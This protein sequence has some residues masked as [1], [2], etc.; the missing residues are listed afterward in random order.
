MTVDAFL[1]IIKTDKTRYIYAA[2]L[3]AFENWSG[4][5]GLVPAKGSMPFILSSSAS[6]VKKNTCPYPYGVF[7]PLPSP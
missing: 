4:I 6:S 7:P 1:D 2:Q 5:R 3:K